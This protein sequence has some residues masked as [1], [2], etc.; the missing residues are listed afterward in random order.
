VLLSATASTSAFSTTS[1]RHATQDFVSSGAKRAGVGSHSWCLHNYSADDIDCSY[2][3]RT[4]CAETASGGLGQCELNPFRQV[5][6]RG[7]ATI[8]STQ[9]RF[10]RRCFGRFME[11]HV[12][13]V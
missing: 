2:T 13:A 10:R 12:F 5:H 3:N 8:L 4:Q 7:G 11:C 6:A 1:Q 9:S